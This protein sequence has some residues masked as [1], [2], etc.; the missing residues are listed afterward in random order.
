MTTQ[1][2][3]ASATAVLDQ[4]VEQACTRAGL[5]NLGPD[6]WREGLTV[7]VDTIETTPGVIPSGRDDLYRRCVDAL[8]NRLRVVDHLK[9]HPDIADEQIERPLVI[10]GLPRTGTTVASC[11]LDQDPAR[12][13][14]LN[15]EAGDCVPPATTETLR[16]DPRCLAKKAELDALAAALEEAHFPIPH[17][18]EADGPTECTFVVNQDF[19]ALLWEA[20]MPTAAYSDWFLDADLTSAYRYER[21]VLQLL[22]SAAPGTW[23][24][25]MPSHAVHVDEL[26]ATFPDARLV[27]AHRDPFKATASALSM[28]DLSRRRVSGDALDQDAIVPA[29]LRQLQAHVERPLRV[30]ERS[31]RD[32]FFHLHYAEF[33]RDPIG[34]M[35]ALYAWAGDELT[36]EVE[37]A[38]L[39]WLKN[40]PQDRFG[41]RPYSL[42]EYGVTIAELETL[43]GEYLATFDV[44]LEQ[45]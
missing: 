3:M 4:L 41:T 16:S 21:S 10:L 39:E 31:P 9:R 40:N 19:K 15:W 12:R 22:Q 30:L 6:S 43:Y 28:Y 13:S 35:R 34:Q 38:M 25:K 8:W 26:L 5:D 23:S 37:A 2:G 33:M 14:L 7:V 44:E 11:L 24:L 32:P 18:E 1:S 42:D 29:T 27:W 45:A 17:W 36:P 20:F